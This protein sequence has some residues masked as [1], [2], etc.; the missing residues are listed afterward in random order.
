MALV[1]IYGTLKR[2]GRNESMMSGT[3]YLRE[4]TTRDAMWDLKA[5]TDFDYP[6]PALTKGAYKI[7]GELYRMTE[8][9]LHTLDIFE[10]AHPHDDQE[11]ERV[12]I[13][14][15]ENIQAQAY[16]ARP[17][18]IKH[19]CSS[20]ASIQLRGHTKIWRCPWS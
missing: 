7:K 13:T 11:Y 6:F 18:L 2:G 9:Q 17:T 8:A 19:S 4:A 5:I 3:Q 10:Q 12:D 20:H 15:E 1:F 14:L 16:I